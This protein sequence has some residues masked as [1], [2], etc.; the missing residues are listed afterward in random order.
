MKMP[1]RLSFYGG[2]FFMFNLFLPRLLAE[3]QKNRI[4]VSAFDKRVDETT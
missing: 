3:S 1:G 2:H 4:F